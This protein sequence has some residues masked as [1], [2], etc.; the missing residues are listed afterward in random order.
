MK[1]LEGTNVQNMTASIRGPI[2]LEGAA[3]IEKGMED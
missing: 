1:I 2:M 3:S